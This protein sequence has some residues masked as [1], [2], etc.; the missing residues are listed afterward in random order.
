MKSLPQAHTLEHSPR[1]HIAEHNKSRTIAQPFEHPSLTLQRPAIVVC[2]RGEEK[3][4]RAIINH[5]QLRSSHSSRGLR[6]LPHFPLAFPL[7]KEQLY[8]RAQVEVGQVE[9]VEG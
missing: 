6:F 2:P 9:E 3:P 4:T 7:R 8:K 5:K 1:T